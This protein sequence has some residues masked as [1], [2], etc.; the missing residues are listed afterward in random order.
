MG[1]ALVTPPAL[2]PL[3]LAEAKVHCRVDDTSEDDLLTALIVAARKH[4]EN[5]TGASFVTQTWRADFWRFPCYRGSLRLPHGPVQSITSISYYDDLGVD[6]VLDASDYDTDLTERLA[7]VWLA[8]DEALP[9][10]QVQPNAVRVTYVAGFGATA[11]SVPQ[12]IRQAMLL[13]IGQW[14]DNRSASAE[15]AL[16][17]TPHAVAALLAGHVIPTLA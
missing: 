7:K 17:E 13:L 12:T 6:T 14:Y 1:Y 2:E 9:A 15:K 4:C 5:Y 3:T 8:P 16:T 10:V 11:A